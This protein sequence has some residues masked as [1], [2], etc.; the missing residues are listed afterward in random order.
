VYLA[1]GLLLLTGTL[2]SGI[3]GTLYSGI[4]GTLWSGIVSHSSSRENATVHIHRVRSIL[5]PKGEIIIFTLT[6]K[7][8]GAM[9]FFMGQSVADR[10]DTPQQL[11]LF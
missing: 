3:A 6:D 5:P 11:E 7:Q 2:W 4:I 1:V 8:F 10:P 9:E